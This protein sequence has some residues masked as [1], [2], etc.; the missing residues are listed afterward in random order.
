MQF[1]I[2]P[3]Q[4][5]VFP[6]RVGYQKDVLTTSAITLICSFADWYKFLRI[7]EPND[8]IPAALSFFDADK[9]IAST[10]IRY[11]Q[12]IHLNEFSC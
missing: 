1:S 7:S 6:H 12:N 11:K 9:T 4:K 2:N 8:K 5:I 3:T 10:A